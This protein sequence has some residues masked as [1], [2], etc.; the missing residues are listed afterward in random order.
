MAIR[1]TLKNPKL[2]LVIA[3][4]VGGVL[5]ALFL[6]ET[7]ISKTSKELVATHASYQK[8]LDQLSTKLTQTEATLKKHQTIEITKTTEG[9]KTVTVTRIVTD[10]E[11]IEK[12]RSEER[13]RAELKISALAAENRELT[14][15][16]SV[17]K[18]PKRLDLFAGKNLLSNGSYMG[19]FTYT[20]WGPFRI[21]AVVGQGTFVPTIGF[22]F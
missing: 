17:H 1:D 2:R 22:S 10:V 14:K 18:N 11:A 12:A 3:F 7:I 9:G 19:G 5:T 6:Q 4:V 15:S 16:L 20:L 21:G 13:S 8:Q